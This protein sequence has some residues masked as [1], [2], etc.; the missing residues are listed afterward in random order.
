MERREVKLILEE[1]PSLYP[2]LSEAISLAYSTAINLVLKETAIPLKSL[3]AAC[4]FSPENILE[5][6]IEFDKG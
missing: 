4:P 6:P 1:N 3:P 2:Y 5:Q